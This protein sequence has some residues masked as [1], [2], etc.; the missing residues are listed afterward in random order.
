MPLSSPSNI[1]N[2][3]SNTIPKLTANNVILETNL[4]SEYAT[5]LA[6]C[7]HIIEQL[8]PIFAQFVQEPDITIKDFEYRRNIITHLEYLLVDSN[9]AEFTID[10]YIFGNKFRYGE[11]GGGETVAISKVANFIPKI[12]SVINQKITVT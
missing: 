7:L 2:E 11:C 1:T 10:F 9:G 8:K 4:L 3:L 12:I 6:S 5:R